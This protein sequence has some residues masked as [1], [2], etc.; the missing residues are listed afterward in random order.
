MTDCSLELRAKQT[1][2]SVSCFSQS[3]LL[4]THT[5]HKKASHS[6]VE[7]IEMCRQDKKLTEKKKLCSDESVEFTFDYHEKNKDELKDKVVA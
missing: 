1:L 2:S 4:Q 3:I 7:M 5:S 6:V